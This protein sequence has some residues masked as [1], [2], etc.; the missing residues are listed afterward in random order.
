[1]FV[2]SI[3]FVSEMS[4]GLVVILLC[5]RAGAPLCPLLDRDSPATVGLCPDVPGASHGAEGVVVSSR[6]AT[7]RPQGTL[8]SEQHLEFFL[9]DFV[10]PKLKKCIGIPTQYFTEL[11]NHIFVEYIPIH[12]GEISI[13]TFASRVLYV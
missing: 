11:I 9:A 6:T 2:L 5:L 12:K 8:T 10:P 13:L 1:M 3:P 4:V 7:V